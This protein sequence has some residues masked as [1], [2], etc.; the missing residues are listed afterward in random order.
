MDLEILAW[1]AGTRFEWQA[2]YLSGRRCICVAGAIFEWQALDL[3]G[4]RYI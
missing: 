3:S 2:L 1:M 4:R